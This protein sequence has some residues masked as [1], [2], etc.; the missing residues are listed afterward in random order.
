MSVSAEEDDWSRWWLPARTSAGRSPHRGENDAIRRV[1]DRMIELAAPHPDDVGLD[2]GCGDGVIGFG[3]LGHLRKVIFSDISEGLI[4][5][6]RDIAENWQMAHRSQFV[7]S[8]AAKLQHIEDNA[9]NV[10]TARSVLCYVSDAAQ[11]ITA[12]HRVLCA[13][14]RMVVF[15]ALNRQSQPSKDVTTLLGFDV[16]AVSDLV[17]PVCEVMLTSTASRAATST[18]FDEMDLLNWAEQAGFLEAS[19]HLQLQYVRRPLHGISEWNDFLNFRARPW[20][21]SVGEAIQ[22]SLSSPQADRLEEYVRPMVE[23]SRVVPR[24]EAWCYLTAVK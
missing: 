10:V 18:I 19:A 24:V 22:R 8:D 14:G 2:V 17:R 5:H 1:R 15:E 21:Y 16:S 20:A 4:S 3:L 6:C 7:V 11:A 13:G 9:V 12:F 23:S